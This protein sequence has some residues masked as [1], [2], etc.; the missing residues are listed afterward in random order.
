MANWQVN[1][2]V[3]L[4]VT[5]GYKYLCTNCTIYIVRTKALINTTIYV[6]GI[7]IGD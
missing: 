1:F 4:V 2:S 6:Q 5:F 7:C 3:I